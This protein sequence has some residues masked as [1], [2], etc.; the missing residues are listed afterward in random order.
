MIKTFKGVLLRKVFIVSGVI[1]FLLIGMCH[2]S[3]AQLS[4][5][6]GTDFWV[7]YGHHQYMET[8]VN[9]MDM[10]LYLSTESQAATVT[11]EIDS[12]GTPALSTTRWRRV[13][14]IPAYTVISTG[15]AN[16][17]PVSVGGTTAIAGLT[18]TMPKTGAYD[19][20][21]FSDAP[22]AGTGGAGIFRKRA[23][24]ITSNVPIVAYAHIYATTTSGATM[25]LPTDT[26]GYT[27]VSINSNQSYASNCYNW[28]YIIASQDST[29][30]EVTP[31][32][33]T[34]A[35]DK[36]G[37]APGVTKTIMLMR[38][39]IYQ[40]IGANDGADANGN[41]GTSSNGKN[42]TGTKIRS[43]GGPSGT[44]CKAI[45]VFAGSSR[46]SNPSNCGSGGG[47]NDNQQLFPL[48]TWGKRYLTTPFS[49]S[50]SASTFGTSVYKVAVKDPT[51][52]VKRNG[53]QLP[54]SSIINNN[55]YVF[56]SN[57]ADYIEADKPMMIVQFMGGGAC[58]GGGDGDPEMIILSP[59]EQAIKKV[60]LYRTNFKAINVSYLTLSVPTNGL[61]SLKI[62]GSST[63]SHTYPHPN[64]SGYTVVV[65]RWQP[66]SEA[67]CS[68]ICDSAFTAITYGEGGAES[69]GYNAGAQLNN[70]N[71]LP[72]YHNTPD[73]SL[74]NVVHPNSFVNTPMKIGAYIAYKPTKMIWRISNIGCSNVTPC[75]D[76][77]VIAPTPIDSVILGAGKY[78]LYH[79]PDTYIFKNSGT[80]YVPILLTSPNSDNGNCK[81]EETVNIEIV[82]KP[83]PTASFTYSQTAGCS[84]TPVQFTAPATTPEGYPIIKYKWIF[85]TNPADTSS[86]Q[87]P[88]FLFN[89]V[90][91]YPVKLIIITQNGGTD[92]ATINVPVT[93]GSGPHASYTTSVTT[94]CVGQSITFTPTSSFPGTTGWWWNFGDGT[95]PVSATSNAAQVHQY[96]TAGIDTVLHVITG[97]GFPCPSDTVKTI[98]TI[99]PIPTISSTSS[100]TTST[101]GGN[102]GAIRI[103]GLTANTTYTVNYTAG[104]T[105]VTVSLTSNASGVV[106]IPNLSAGTYTN[107]FVTVGSC[108]SNTIASQGVFEPLVPA[109]PTITSNSPVCEGSNIALTASSTTTGVSYSWSG[110]NSFTSTI[111]NPQ[112]NGV[113]LSAA[114]TYTVKA[115]KN[116]CN[117]AIASTT[118]VVNAIPVIGIVS[119]VNPTSCGTATGGLTLHGLI[120]N[121]ANYTIKYTA[122]STTNSII[123]ASDLTGALFIPNLAAGTYS[124]ITVSLNGCGSAAVGPYTL[125]DPNPPATPTV[126]S[127]SPICAG[128]T[129][130]LT[131]N[132]AT[133]G[134]SY[135]WTGPNG[136]TSTLQNPTISSAATTATGNYTVKVKL[137]GCSSAD[138]TVSVVVNAI[139][140]VPVVGSNSPICAGSTLNL[141]A[142]SSTSGVD[143]NWTGP[144]SFVSVLQNPTISNATTSATGTYSVTAYLNGCY[145][146]AG[147]VSVTVNAIPSITSATVANTTTCATT[148]GSISLNGLVAN[149]IYTVIYYKGS[150][151]TTLT[152]TANASGIVIIPNLSAGTYSNIT[153]TLNNCVSN[154]VGP[155]TIVDPT[156]PTTP[157]IVSNNSPVCSGSSIVLTASST[158]TNPTFSWTTPSGTTLTGSTV[159]ISNSA[160]TDAGTYTVKVIV[161]SCSSSTT[162]ASVTVKPTPAITNTSSTNPTA[163]ATATGSI[164]L[165]GLTAGT[166]Y[167]I[168][169]TKNSSAQT[170]LSLTA[171]ASGSVTISNL[172]SGVY[173]GI[174]ATLNGCTSTPVGA[175]TLADPNPP[176]T[177]TITASPNDTLCSGTNLVLTASSTTA[178]VSFNWTGP[179][180]FVATNSN[181]ATLNNITA[182]GA[183]VYTVTATLN[184]CTSIAATMTIVVNTTPVIASSSKTNPTNCN[185]NT[186]SI[187]LNGLQASTSFKVIYT[188][189]AGTPD[190]VTISSNAS[191]VIVIPNL[192][193][194]TYTTVSVLLGTCQSNIVGSFVLTDP[195]APAKPVFTTNSPICEGSTLN[196]AATSATSGVSYS[197]AGPNG[198]TYT[199]GGTLPAFASAT[200]NL[201]GYYKATVTLNSCSSID[202]VLVTV[203]PMP[204]VDFTPSAFVCMPNGAVSFTNNSSIASGTLSYV[205]DFGDASTSTLISPSHVYSAVNNYSIKLTA[206]SNAGCTKFTTKPF[207]AFYPKPFAGFTVT[208]DSLCQGA[209]NTFV[210]TSYAT[211]STIT[212]RM[213]NFEEPNSWMTTSSVNQTKLYINPGNYTVQLVVKNQ[214]G[215]VSDT[216]KKPVKV[217]LQPVVD[218]GSPIIVTAGTLVK[219]APFV[220]DSATLKFKWSP[221]TGLTSADSLRPTFT[222]TQNRVYKLTATGLGNCTATDSV[223]VTVLQ[224]LRIPNAF[225]PNGDGKNDKWVIGNITDYSFA[226]VEVFNRNGQVVFRSNGNKEPWDGT[227]HGKNV[228]VGV[229]YYIIDF[230][231]KFGFQKM[232]GSIT[233][234]R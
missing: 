24:H 123:S 130:N 199:T 107:I 231:G 53:V 195:A 179:N 204:V 128:A 156:P 101:C 228:P 225:S 183:G 32:V 232:T 19:C 8:G 65:K 129:L 184:S 7:G 125:T 63:F 76:V 120:P 61:P 198:F 81:N 21:L 230:Q 77:T 224:T 218:A 114:G 226:I 40:I 31:S 5:N 170:P 48:H 55:Y 135:E 45:A 91:T 73:T 13:Y 169:Y 111:Q 211:N 16:A 23:I 85:T 151:P 90:N 54:L 191:G 83:K 34:R 166:T 124:N 214:Q 182:L 93:M 6:K 217:Y 233:L 57:T 35:Q 62:D 165:G 145:S 234:L 193:A 141:T 82:V 15:V 100:D 99:R 87:N 71:G 110:P 29:Y 171:N 159:T 3:Y 209:T 102:D 154:I 28:T 79:L 155:F 1:V 181:T 185:S 22:P 194:G 160:A 70:T 113:A 131:S 46:T 4:S 173:N 26:W 56:E 96:N 86:L 104:S 132:S 167:T 178:G 106:V 39:Q 44:D 212:T 201:S 197:W 43:V 52:I 188:K 80:F 119:V 133:A 49:V 180:S 105:P 108:P 66:A 227:Y 38:G 175:F 121:T 60:V 168:N 74:I 144:N 75:A 88:S 42:L 117:S 153:A 109:T 148:T 84:M 174:T 58:M 176:A 72:G 137:A 95:T 203:N 172:T 213:W 17:N 14:T 208:P 127:N 138:A 220:N 207:S 140:G 163:C 192:G 41:G 196:I 189:N 36:T 51:T 223:I 2:Q 210:D 205:W 147:T 126:S 18:G 118:V 69:Y 219:L 187:T 216:A 157:S 47:D 33:L 186:G 11:V 10:V 78:Y 202:S 94:I 162:S 64:K 68:V 59:I 9:D 152:L 164:T 27:Y 158:E 103:N 139:P 142:S 149:Q 143:Y 134:V 215:C 115:I 221:A 98:V 112:L 177:P 37:L 89:A 190:T 146:T 12:S 200:T 222:A 122:G 30:I 92:T 50:S 116:N 25:L 150:T 229:Y 136:W 97:T 161:N 67:Q 20:R 206:T